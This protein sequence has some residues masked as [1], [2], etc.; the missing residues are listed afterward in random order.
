MAGAIALNG[1]VVWT[2][3]QPLAPVGERLGAL[4]VVERKMSKRAFESVLVAAARDARWEQM[5]ATADGVRRAGL[6]AD[7]AF[8]AP[9]AMPAAPPPS[10]LGREMA[11]AGGDQVALARFNKKVFGPCP[12]AVKV[13][14]QLLGEPD[15]YGAM[16]RGMPAALRQCSCATTPED[17]RTWFWYVAMA[18]ALPG[19]RVIRV[20]PGDLKARAVRAGRTDTWNDTHRRVIGTADPGTGNRPVRLELR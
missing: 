6:A 9:R 8:E 19:T 20:I 4:L 16:V 15:K 1:S 3:G 17:A 13:F 5:V 12:D 11:K 7:L 14:A 10:P 2:A 18:S